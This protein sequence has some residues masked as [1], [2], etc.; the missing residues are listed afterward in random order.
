MQDNEENKAPPQGTGGAMNIEDL[1]NLK[2]LTDMRWIEIASGD[3]ESHIQDDESA[4]DMIGKKPGTYYRDIIFAL[5]QITPPRRRGAARLEGDPQA[6]VP[7]ER[8]ARP[9]R[10]HPRGDARLLHQ[11]QAQDRVSENR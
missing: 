7:H 11:H 4:L 2:K 3:V 10:G 9:Q 8:K 1:D 6:Q 5:I